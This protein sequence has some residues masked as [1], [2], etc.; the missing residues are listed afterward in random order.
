MSLDD[1]EAVHDRS[2][3]ATWRNAGW[4][5]FYGGGIIGT[6]VCYGL[7]QER[8]MAQP[9]SGGEFFRWSLFLVLFNRIVAIAFC[10]GMIL[11]NGEQWRMV[12]PMWKYF[13]VSLSIV[14][15]SSCQYEA[16]K[17]VSFPVQMLGKSFKMMPVML[18]GM[19]ISQKRYSLVD[20]LVAAAVTEGVVQFLFFGPIDA[21]H[22]K[23]NSIYGLGL[24]VVF[25]FFDGFTSTQEE[26]LFR[27]NGTTKYNQMLYVN[28]GSAVISLGGLLFSGHFLLAL[29]F[30][31]HHPSLLLDAGLLSSSAVAAQYFIFS[32]VKEYGAL[33]FAAAMNVRQVVSVLLSYVSYGHRITFPQTAGLIQIFGALFYKTYRSVSDRNGEAKPLL[34][35]PGGGEGGRQPA[36]AV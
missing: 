21:R 15:A 30:V 28:L 20:W 31:E 18:W 25:L 2:R 26:K 14:I 11:A 22:N 16:L 8:I 12:A 17:Y 23:G 9:Y 34:K 3:W 1:E 7:L 32:M 27:D 29:G 19:A 10:V 6:L 5:V 35:S 13:V 36:G 33:V 24:L 4:C